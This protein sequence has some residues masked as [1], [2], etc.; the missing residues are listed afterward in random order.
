ML[1]NTATPKYY[2]EFRERVIRGE[3][4]VCHEISM[5][6]N[7]V[8]GLIANPKYYYDDSAIDGFIDFCESELTLVDGSDFHML[9]SFKLWAEDLLA[10]FYYETVSVPVPD[11]SSR[12]VHYENRRIKKRLHNLQYIITGRS[13]AKSI[14]LTCIQAYFQNV[15]TSTTAQITTSPTARQSDEVIGPYKTAIARARGPLFKFLTEGSLQNTTGSR[16]NRQKL[17]PTKEGIVNFLTNSTLKIY[18]MSID[19]LQGQRCKIATIDEWLSGNTRE[20]PINAICQSAA[21]IDDWAVIATSSEGT[22]RNGPGDSIKMELLHVLKG[23]Y[24]NDHMSIWYY[25]LDD[26][27]EVREPEMWMKA[28]PNLGKTVSY[29]TYQLDVLKAEREPASRNE[30]LAKRFGL[31]LEGSTYFFTYDE[32]QPHRRRDFWGLPCSLGADLSRGDDFCAFTFLFPLRGGEFGIKTRCYITS[33]TLNKLSSALRDK[34]EELMKEG[35]LVV[36]DGI[37]L[38]MENVYEDLDRFID[39]SEYDVRSFGFDPY[40][41]KEFVNL[42]TT[43]NGD[44]GVE[45]VQQGRRTESVPLGEL[46]KLAEARMLIFDQEMMKFCMG[47]CVV[48][49]DINGNRQLNK[50]RRDQK[51]DAVSAMMDAYIAYKANKEAFE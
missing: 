12:G 17:A 22:V 34:Y 43:D 25:K 3:I 26:I 16:A 23:E 10:W 32:T 44:Y 14:Y 46:K 9:D 47:N 27:S 24:Q 15:D 48:N 30:I 4:P 29:E 39:E 51:I 45:K 37:T 42:W 40:H 21:K 8:D 7:I 41:A 20:D 35:S 18:P 28:N 6:M 5:Y 33:D 36:L 19:K 50:E 13:S 49:V 1:S 38:E 31:P 2:G 11:M